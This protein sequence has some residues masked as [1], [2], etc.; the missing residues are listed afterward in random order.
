MGTLTKNQEHGRLGLQIIAGIVFISFTILST[1]AYAQKVAPEVS[2]AS[3][4]SFSQ[5]DVYI[6]MSFGEFAVTTIGSSNQIITQGFLQPLNI[7][8]PCSKPEFVYYPN[9]V[10]K[11]IT[12]E[13]LD[14]DVDLAYVE[15]FDL[16][17]TTVL[18]A[19][20]TDNLVDLSSLGVG[21]YIIRTFN[22]SMQ[23]L[24]SIKVVKVT[25]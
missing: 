17:G 18:T 21:V 10:V 6:D 12:I 15:I 20:P 16:L 14:C 24:G 3:G 25:A 22:S 11:T 1:A 8:I 5:G 23:F 13:A 9:P 2:F 19:A 7:E 4:Y